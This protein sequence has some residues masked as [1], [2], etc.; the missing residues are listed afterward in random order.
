MIALLAAAYALGS[1]GGLAWLDW[2]KRLIPEGQR[3]SFLARRNLYNSGLSL[4][5]SLLAAIVISCWSGATNSTGG[6]LAVFGVAMACGLL[7]VILLGR[8]PA[9]DSS[10]VQEATQTGAWRQ[11]LASSNF[12]QLLYGYAVWQFASQLAA[13]FF[14]VYMLQRLH[15]PFWAVT[16]LA[17][18][19]TLLA[20]SLNATWTRL[21]LR[22][23]VKPIVLLATLGDV[24]IPLGWLLVHPQT[25]WLVI[26]LHM[27]TLFNPPLAM[28]PNNFLLKIVP[29]RNGASYLALFNATTGTIGALGA[30]VG[31]WLAMTL[32][33]Q[34]HFGQIELTGIQLVFLLSGVGKF[35]AF[36]LLSHVEEPG[37][38]ALESVLRGW[39]ARLRLHPAS[40]TAVVAL[41]PAI[42][43]E[44]KRAA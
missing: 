26:P 15:I 29:A 17:T 35:V 12:R 1:V 23:G 37:S 18:M 11:P 40:P 14:A 7:G 24:L 19:G 6:F 10:E 31:G 41:Q 25:V 44:S 2:I 33:G 42:E 13:P 5:M 43:E 38:V 39:Q 34:W 27:L 4:A 36:V 9:A 28:G 32:Q 30:V 21:K 20:L 22:F 8:I 3:I 16:A